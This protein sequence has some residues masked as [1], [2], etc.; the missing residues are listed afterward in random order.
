[1]S[2]HH[3]P[4]QTQHQATAP[5]SNRAAHLALFGADGASR[6]IESALRPYSVALHAAQEGAQ[7][8]G[9]STAVMLTQRIIERLNEEP[10]SL[11]QASVRRCVNETIDYQLRHDMAFRLVGLAQALRPMSLA[12]VAYMNTLLNAS[13]Q[14]IF[15]IGPTGTGKTHLAIAAGLNA[16][17]R[18]RV[19]KLV[20]TRPHDVFEGETITAAVRA[21]TA[22]DDQ[23]APLEDELHSL[24]S[25]EEVNRLIESEQ[26]EILPLGHMRGRTFND[27][28]IV[29]D[30]AQNI[31]IRRMR[32]V[33]TRLGRGS[34]MVLAGDP[35]QVHLHEDEPSGLAHLLNLIGGADFALVHEFEPSSIIRNEVVAQ[36]E[37]LYARDG[38]ARIPA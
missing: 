9:D 32:M 26:L 29:V 8:S 34:R 30:D 17:A 15:G 25:A 14:L 4:T 23:L 13:Q 35:A 36:L 7:L 20:A 27:A 10:G 11:D 37:T 5:I 2:A 31:S 16:L 21:E 12:Q 33:V 1:M 6:F 19:K 18:G 22:R 28:F 38:R 3:D 24:V